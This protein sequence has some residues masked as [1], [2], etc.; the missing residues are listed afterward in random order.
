MGFPRLPS[1]SLPSE[2]VNAVSRAQGRPP[3]AAVFAAGMLSSCAA[4]FVSYPLALVRTRM[5][6]QG[7]GGIALKCAGKRAPFLPGPTQSRV[8]AI[9]RFHA[10]L[11]PLAPLQNPRAVQYILQGI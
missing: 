3:P 2:G 1:H 11:L 5:Q 4:Q 8:S 6:A 7:V 10:P 9:L